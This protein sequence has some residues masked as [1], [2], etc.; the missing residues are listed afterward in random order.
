MS[1]RCPPGKRQQCDVARLLDGRGQPVLMR[2]AHA[3]Q[4]PGHDLAALRHE[5]AEQPVILVV[6]V[7]DL[8]RA[9]LA[10]LLAPEKLASTFTRRAARP[11]TPTASATEP[12]TVSSRT[13]SVAGGP[14]WPF[15]YWR[16][17]F[18]L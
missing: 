2:R 16:W 17:C 13:W 12:R 4:P 1:L 7:R 9:E 5:L 18:S 6:D 3:G 10:D 8:L 11:G 15:R 14:R